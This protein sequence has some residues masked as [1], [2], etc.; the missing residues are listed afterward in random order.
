MNFIASQAKIRLSHSVGSMDWHGNQGSTLGCTR[1]FLK[2]LMGRHC[3][4]SFHRPLN[5]LVD[6]CHAASRPVWPLNNRTMI[7]I[8]CLN[9]PNWLLYLVQFSQSNMVVGGLYFPTPTSEGER[10]TSESARTS[11]SRCQLKGL[12]LQCFVQSRRYLSML[13]CSNA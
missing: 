3:F 10:S 5:K 2:A 13:K 1:T 6:E 12:R 4:G 11:R 7:C 8:G 9:K